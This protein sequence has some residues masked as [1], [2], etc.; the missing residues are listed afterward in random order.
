MKKIVLFFILIVFILSSCGYFNLFYNAKKYYKSNNFNLSEEKCNKIINDPGL[1][2]LHDDAYFLLAQIKEKTNRDTEAIYY[3]KKIVKQYP[4]S[5]HVENSINKIVEIYFGNDQN[6]KIYEFLKNLNNYTQTNIVNY[7]YAKTLFRLKKYEEF[8]RIVKNLPKNKTRNKE[9][10]ALYYYHKK[11]YSN[12][13]KIIQS[14]QDEK[15]NSFI[16]NLFF[17][18]FNKYIAKN[19]IKNYPKYKFINHI[20][21]P[22]I[23]FNDIIKYKNEISQLSNTQKINFYTYLL[24]KAITNEMFQISENLA[25]NINLI[26][27][28]IS[29]SRK[30]SKYRLILKKNF[31]NYKELPSNW[32]KIFSDGTENNFYL[33]SKNTESNTE[34]EL[35]KLE[36]SRWTKITMNSPPSNLPDKHLIIWDKNYKRWIFLEP[37]NSQILILDRKNYSWD[38]LKIEGP[39][40]SS[41]PE[42][43]PIKKEN[44]IYLF[45][46]LSNISNIE[47]EEDLLKTK[48]LKILGYPPSLKN[49]LLIPF[50]QKNSFIILGGKENGIKN[51]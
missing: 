29:P 30:K 46:G 20:L 35:Y 31:I 22:K 34:L 37:N 40:L 41:I 14:F 15:K 38:T 10:W 27:E 19:Y 50:Q 33:F 2:Y 48:K 44:Q 28:E 42:Y 7:Y 24:E 1:K 23:N 18:T 47:I 25:L 21:L 12:F 32:Q 11:K 26:K 6:E 43:K 5:K 13:S 45:F 17:K 16:L 36:N 39:L 51:Y 8:V 3:L 9:L 4:Q 49:Y